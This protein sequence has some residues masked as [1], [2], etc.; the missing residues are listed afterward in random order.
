MA[1]NA[2][3]NPK[4][5]RIKSRAD[6]L[7]VQRSGLSF[8]NRELIVCYKIVPKD[9][10]RY[11]VTVSRKVG[12]AVVRNRVKRR[13]R[14]GIRLFDNRPPG[15]EVVFI[16]KSNAATAPTACLIQSV[17]SAFEKIGGLN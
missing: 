13:I 9:L 14:E 3:G 11:G 1:N 4:S 7:K 8:R 12:N 5:M 6:F 15:V 2:N 17:N 10:S 16:A